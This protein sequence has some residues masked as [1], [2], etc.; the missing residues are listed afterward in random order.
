M[1]N[2]SHRSLRADPLVLHSNRLHKL[3]L[4]STVGLLLVVFSNQANGQEPDDIAPPPL[5]ML[6]KTEKSELN[7]RTDVKEHAALALQLMDTRLKA[8]EKFRTDENY[9]LMYAEL[10][11]FHG[12]MDHTLDFLLRSGTDGKVL[13]SLKKFD[14]GLRSFVPRVETLRRELPPN[15]EPYVK[16]LLKYISET[17]E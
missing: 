17:R 1:K 3:V 9:T 2:K 16:D 5:K 11:G 13:N 14:I 10:G 4:I 7:A 8:A 6:S 12:L 15:F